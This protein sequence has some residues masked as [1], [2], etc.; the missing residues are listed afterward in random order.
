MNA[1]TTTSRMS[2]GDSLSINVSTCA[3]IIGPN[4]CAMATSMLNSRGRSPPGD[5]P[6]EHAGELRAR[7]LQDASAPGLPERRVADAVGHQMRHQAAAR[8]S[9]LLRW[10]MV[11]DRQEI[12]PQIAGLD[13]SGRAAPAMHPHHHLEAERVLVRPVLV[14]RRL[15]DAGRL[16]DRVHAGGV[17]AALGEQFQRRR[18]A[19][20]RAPARSAAGP[21][22][23]LDLREGASCQAEEDRADASQ[24]DRRRSRRR[25]ARRR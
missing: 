7:R 23:D 10:L 20:R 11:E 2:V 12:R 6:L 4:S 15:A 16:G 1:S 24:D 25:N 3:S 14:D 19:R 13:A 8:L 18:R 22:S 9:M 5:R 21:S 17:D